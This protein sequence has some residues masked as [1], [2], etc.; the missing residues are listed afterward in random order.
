MPKYNQ[1]TLNM[2][3]AMKK[4]YGKIVEE[5]TVN[6]YDSLSDGIKMI[7]T[8]KILLKDLPPDEILQ[9]APGIY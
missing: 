8:D 4:F 5:E 2:G 7:Y 1:M 3:L 6:F 9:I